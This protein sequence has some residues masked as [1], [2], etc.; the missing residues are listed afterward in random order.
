MKTPISRGMASRH[1]E[2]LYEVMRDM[3]REMRQMTELMGQGEF[4][5]E[6]R[7]GMVRRM[8][9]MSSMSQRMSDLLARLLDRGEWTS[10][11]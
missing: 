1:H 8:E 9:R 5:A 6:Q 10:R 3:T 11:S 4:P 2:A 7:N